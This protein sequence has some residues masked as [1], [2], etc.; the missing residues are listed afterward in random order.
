[1]AKKEEILAEVADIARSSELR[2]LVKAVLVGYLGR[3]EKLKGSETG[4]QLEVETDIERV[5]ALS[6]VV[7]SG[8]L[9]LLVRDVNLGREIKGARANFCKPGDVHP[10]DDTKLRL[11]DSQGR[12]RSVNEVVVQMTEL[13]PGSPTHR[14]DPIKSGH[15][16]S[17]ATTAGKGGVLVGFYDQAGT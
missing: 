6:R 8:L 9:G 13:A 4:K 12:P 14:P 1:M 10:D 17:A 5:S 2:V 3:L 15:T 11:V 16:V 7:S